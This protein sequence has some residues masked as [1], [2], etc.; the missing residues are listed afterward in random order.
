MIILKKDIL[1][2]VLSKEQILNTIIC[3]TVLFK[4]EKFELPMIFSS[5]YFS[6][7]RRTSTEFC[8]E[9]IR[10]IVNKSQ[11]SNGKTFYCI[12]SFNKL[13][14]KTN[15]CVCIHVLKSKIAEI[16]KS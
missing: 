5:D 10:K 16:P 3:R 7:N 8:Y 15:M 11:P 12:V 14:K 13:Y 1:E 6:R 4:R 2:I 9:I